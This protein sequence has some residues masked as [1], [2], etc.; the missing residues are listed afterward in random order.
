[1]KALNQIQYASEPLKGT[2]A[3]DMNTL[4]YVLSPINKDF[5]LEMKGRKG[6]FCNW[7]W[8]QI[9]YAS[10][11]LKSTTAPVTCQIC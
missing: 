8:Y 1:M 7:S 6:G 2:T 3:P 5:S 11:P 10:E 9:Q 4:D